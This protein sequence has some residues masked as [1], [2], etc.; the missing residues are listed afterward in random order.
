MP[1]IRSLLIFLAATALSG[2]PLA[3]EPR[4]TLEALPAA[5]IPATKWVAPWLDAAPR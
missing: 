4:F 3:A 2:L 1:A 5:P